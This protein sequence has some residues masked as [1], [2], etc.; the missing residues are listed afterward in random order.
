MD[1]MPIAAK[2]L[3]PHKETGGSSNLIDND[4]EY[5]D[6][7]DYVDDD[8]KNYSKAHKTKKVNRGHLKS[9]ESNGNR[10]SGKYD[11]EEDVSQKE[12]LSYSKYMPRFVRYYI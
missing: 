12:D 3:F 11:T 2:K 7:S 5:Y 1:P 4:Q 10:S 9:E 6:D 8:Y